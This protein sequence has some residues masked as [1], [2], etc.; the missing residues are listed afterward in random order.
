MR[1]QSPRILVVDDDDLTAELFSA[2]IEEAGLGRPTICTD[3]RE[4]VTLVGRENIDLVLLDL[5]MPHVGGMELISVLNEQAP[6]V[7]VIV[8]TVVD[9]VDIAV[10]CMKH[11]AFDF[12]S[13]P[14]DDA[15][16]VTAVRHALR[17]RELEDEV[18]TLSGLVGAN[19]LAQPQK[20]SS[21]ITHSETMYRMFAYVEAIAPSPKSVLI[22]GESG[23]GKELVARA[24]HDLS[25]RTGHF[26]AVNV[27]GLDETMVSDTLFGHTKGA[28]TGAA[29]GRS[30]LIEQAKGGTLFLDEIGDMAINAQ[31]KLLRLLQEEEY[32]PLGSDVPRKA[33]VRIV[34]ATN[35]D[36]ESRQAEGT[37]RKDLYYRLLS[38]T[39]RIP[40]LRERAEDIPLLVDH[41]VAYAAHAV[42][43]P[44][45]LVP[46]SLYRMLS[47]YSF[48]G[49]VR[50]L[51]SIL[52]DAVSVTRGDSLETTSIDSHIRAAGTN[53][54]DNGMSG[55]ETSGATTTRR[56][57]LE[58]EAG[59]SESDAPVALQD[60]FPKLDEVE[61]YLIREALRRVNGN[62]TR[63]AELLGVSQ[64]TLSRRLRRSP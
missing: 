22:L 9:R 25:G 40:P 56:G 63:A 64:S 33:R 17:I 15:R 61:E 30:G 32:Y 5:N 1:D 57:D 49:N 27:S 13:K 16:L 29:S 36:L 21:I 47:E 19:D 20:F 44:V 48:P 58:T 35:A 51:Q 54:A 52:Y 43:R 50:E 55:G 37:F 60:R 41:F 38:H 45:P 31:L 46:D 26:V 39:V 8:V 10:E 53:G 2:H 14:V 18:T 59:K 23:S 6:H 11:G 4:V 12:L 3:S 34:A 62:Q 24:I 7:T 28:Y 42:D